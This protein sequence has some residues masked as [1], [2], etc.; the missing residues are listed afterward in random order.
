MPGSGD[1]GHD[2][3]LV[4]PQPVVAAAAIPIVQPQPIAQPLSIPL[5]QPVASVPYRAAPMGPLGPVGPDGEQRAWDGGIPMQER[6]CCQLFVMAC[7]LAGPGF[8]FVMGGV[9]FIVAAGAVD[10]DED[11]YF[12]CP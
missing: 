1:H 12:G 2:H 8:C 11:Y 4:Q 7:C 9:G 10:V 5:Q 6:N 3:C